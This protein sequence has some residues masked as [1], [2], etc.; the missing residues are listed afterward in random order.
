MENKYKLV[1]FDLDGTLADTSQ[2]I[3]NAHR[4]TADKMGIV[5]D[6]NSL[7]G[8]IGGELLKIYKTRF[9]LDDDSSR[10]AVDIYR[11]WYQEKGIYQAEIYPGI[12]ELL[13]NLKSNGMKLAVATL[14]REDF[15][16]KML[17]DMKV[18]RMFDH[19]LGMDIEDTLNKEKLLRKCV[20]LVNVKTNEAVLIGDSMNDAK[21]ADACEMDFIGVTYGFGFSDKKDIN[22]VGAIFA[23]DTPEEVSDFLGL[24]NQ[25]I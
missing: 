8:V 12:E 6:E 23:A 9:Q 10:K 13:V 2:G 21:G 25:S 18:A 24:L 7:N 14:K 4:Y 19:I 1:I 22:S 17:E 5:L 20:E 11:L 15:A 3:Y 16:K